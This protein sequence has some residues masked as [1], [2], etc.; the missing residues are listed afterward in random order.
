MSHELYKASAVDTNFTKA[1][2]K[3]LMI[4]CVNITAPLAGK[5]RSLYWNVITLGKCKAYVVKDKQGALVHV[6]YVIP[7]CFKFPFMRR[8]DIEI[9]PCH[10]V[11]NYR[12]QGIYPYILSRILQE[13][14]KQNAA[15][16]MI[17]DNHNYSSIKGVLKAGFK[18]I[19]SLKKSKAGIY[20][21]KG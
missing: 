19:N 16:Y 6:S 2:S 12:G 7:K 21:V 10:T 15:A 8:G 1:I 9:D 14:L 4:Q 3:D 20:V 5:F 18:K 13:E 17:V 11:S